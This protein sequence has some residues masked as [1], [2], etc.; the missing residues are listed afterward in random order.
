MQPEHETH[1]LELLQR[2]ADGVEEWFCLTCGRHMQLRHE[3]T[4]VQEILAEGDRSAS[5]SNRV[6]GVQATAL[7]SMAAALAATAPVAQTSHGG[8]G[9]DGGQL[10]VDAFVDVGEPERSDGL[11]P[12]ISFLKRLG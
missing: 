1:T 4:F 8:I 12:W 10:G 9:A 2:T 11:A 5:H 7:T 3:P 6:G